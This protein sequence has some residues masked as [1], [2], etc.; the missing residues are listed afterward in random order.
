MKTTIY[1]KNAG[2]MF[3]IFLSII[4]CSN[5]SSVVRGKSEDGKLRKFEHCKTF[6]YEII[7]VNDKKQGVISIDGKQFPQIFI[8]VQDKDYAYLFAY[9][10]KKSSVLGYNK[11]DK[12]KIKNSDTEITD[13]ELSRGWYLG[14]NC[15]AGTPLCWIFAQWNGGSAFINSEGINEVISDEP[16]NSIFPLSIK[17]KNL[18]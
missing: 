13:E 4:S 18:Y 8:F 17:N 7:M 14:S 2:F 5:G 6:D 3:I 9:D 1:I 16:F 15:K 11:T 12:I 10:L